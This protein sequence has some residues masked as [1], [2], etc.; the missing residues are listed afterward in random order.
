MTVLEMNQLKVQFL[1]GA[2]GA[3]TAVLVDMATWQEIIQA[4]EDAEDVA[5][6][7]N[8]LAKLDRAGGNL[9]KAGFTPWAVARAELEALDDAQK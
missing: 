9:K 6:A 5:T 7:R 8:S 3:P 1:V 4:L 2:E